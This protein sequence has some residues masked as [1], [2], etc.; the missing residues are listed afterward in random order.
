MGKPRFSSWSQIAPLLVILGVLLFLGPLATAWF[1]IISSCTLPI[2]NRSVAVGCFVPP[3]CA[4][5]FNRILC[6]LLFVVITACGFF[7]FFFLWIFLLFGC[8]LFMW[9]CRKIQK[10]SWHDDHHLPRIPIG[11]LCQVPIVDMNFKD[12][13]SPHLFLAFELRGWVTWR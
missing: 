12:S 13:P 10:L 3:T 1:P 4:V 5:G 6:N 2:T 11:E 9:V 8:S 7:F